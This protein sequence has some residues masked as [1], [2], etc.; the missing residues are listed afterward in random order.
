MKNKYNNKITNICSNN[1]KI[2]NRKMN[3]IMKVNF[4]VKLR[5]VNFNNKYIKKN[6][7]VITIIL[8]K[9]KIR[10]MRLKITFRNKTLKNRIKMKY[11]N[12]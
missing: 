9:L 6:H 1:S 2:R 7:L 11:M 3:M 5:I 4:K 10:R 8:S 12:E